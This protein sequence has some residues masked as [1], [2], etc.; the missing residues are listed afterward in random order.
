[1]L[2]MIAEELSLVMVANKIIPIEN[3]KYYIYGIELVL[4]NVLICLGIIA[5]A[6]IT[7]TILISIIFSLS[8][9]ILRAYVGGYHSNTYLKCFCISVINYIIMLI[10]NQTAEYKLILSCVLIGISVPIII[11]FAPVEHENKPLSNEQKKKYKKVSILIISII[12]ASFVISCVFS[13][14]DIS[15]AISWAVFGVFFLLLFSKIHYEQ[16]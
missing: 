16:R 3:R 15:F 2:R 4:N 5:L 11:K 1:M 10:L 12:T 6:I 13:R 8:F 14:L 9:C 7:K